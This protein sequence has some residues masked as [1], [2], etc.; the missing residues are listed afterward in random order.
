MTRHLNNSFHID[1]VYAE[2]NMVKE[3]AIM[4]H[5]KWIN[6]TDHLPLVFKI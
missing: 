2:E 5:Y 1:F 4:D 3:F 6:V